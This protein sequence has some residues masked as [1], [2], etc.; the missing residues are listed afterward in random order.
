MSSQET[1]KTATKEDLAWFDSKN[2]LHCKQFSIDDCADFLA[3]RLS[4]FNLVKDDEFKEIVSKKIA[5]GKVRF[6]KFSEH[7]FFS[8]GHSPYWNEGL[9][10]D[11]VEPLSVEQVRRMSEALPLQSESKIND[12]EDLYSLPARKALTSKVTGL[13]LTSEE[14]DFD[15]PFDFLAAKKCLELTA[16]TIHFSVDLFASNEEILKEL[17]SLLP[18]YRKAL[19]DLNLELSRDFKPADIGL[20]STYKAFEYVDILLWATT[21]GL[22]VP[23][24]LMVSIL[25]GDNVNIDEV[26]FRQ[27]HKIFYKKILNNNYVHAIRYFSKSQS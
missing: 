18:A 15:V 4:D 8:R 27:K 14:N 26:V 13:E 19:A 23:D 22:K 21:K 16:G 1:L 24:K 10:I 20:F 17:K 5:S 11:H 6:I 12:V 7:K 2:Y 3:N 9:A 25:F